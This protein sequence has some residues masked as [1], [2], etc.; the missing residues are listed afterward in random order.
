MSRINL[1]YFITLEISIS[2]TYSLHF[3]WGF[4]FKGSIL[5]F[6]RCNEGWIT[7]CIYRPGELVKLINF[8]TLFFLINVLFFHYI[9]SL[10]IILNRSFK[11]I[12]LSPQI[13]L[14]SW[15]SVLPLLL[16]PVMPFM[17]RP[18]LLS[19]FL[20]IYCRLMTANNVWCSWTLADNEMHSHWVARCHH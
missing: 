9:F 5:Y 4:A 2:L 13:V 15:P 1:F 3:I 16:C 18:L 7:K 14:P 10:I 11:D 19:F 12:N 6:N 17:P 8:L 20:H